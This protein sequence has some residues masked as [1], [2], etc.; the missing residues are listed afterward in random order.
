MAVTYTNQMNTIL[1]TVE[2][3]IEDEFPISVMDEHEGNESIVINPIDD[4]LIDHLSSANT[5]S[6]AVEIIYT[7]QKP[8][9]MEY[10]KTHLTN[11]AERIKRLLFNNSN[12]S[13]G[14][15]V[16]H[17]GRVDSI[18]YSQ[19]EEKQDVWMANII[20]SVNITEALS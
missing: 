17:D 9:G 1:D 16:W 12:Y 7:M 18:I 3:L 10:T 13:T 4:T 2:K 14:G 8:G 15:Y 20:F 6:F 19:D 5:R 11:R